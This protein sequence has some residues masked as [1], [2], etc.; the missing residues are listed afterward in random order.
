MKLAVLVAAL[1]LCAGASA[2]A[3]S[4]PP[5]LPQTVHVIKL[6]RIHLRSPA[7]RSCMAREQRLKIARWLAPVACEQPPRSQLLFSVLFGD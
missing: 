2:S 7:G 1:F 5:P 3:A 4:W 6:E